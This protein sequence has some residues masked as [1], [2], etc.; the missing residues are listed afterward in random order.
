MGE[1]IFESSWIKEVLARVPQ[2]IT[3]FS[4]LS[5]RSRVSFFGFPLGNLTVVLRD[6]SSSLMTCCISETFMPILV[7]ISSISSSC[8]GV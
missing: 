3:R 1:G 4:S 6:Y 2:L 7:I 8:M 5:P